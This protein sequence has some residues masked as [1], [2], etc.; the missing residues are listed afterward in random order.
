MANFLTSYNTYIK[1]IEGGYANHPADKG[2]ETYGG[3]AR[4]YNPGWKGWTDIDLIK[5]T[6][7]KDKVIP[8][9]KKFSPLLDEPVESFYE[10]LWNKNNFGLIKNQQVTDILFDWFINS[11]SNAASTKGKETYGVDEILNRDFGFKLPIDSKFDTATINAI[12]AVNQEQLYNTIKTERKKFYETLIANNPSQKVFETGWFKR[13]AGF[14]GFSS[15]IS[16]ILLLLIVFL[17]I[18]FI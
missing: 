2:G 14:P 11:G 16:L 9:N 3:I 12:N 1:P 17:F 18:I 10:N 8:N 15:G 5:R 7:Y 6:T 4:N 13:L